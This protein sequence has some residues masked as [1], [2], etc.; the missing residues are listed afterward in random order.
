[1]DGVWGEWSDWGTCSKTC[2]PGTQTASRECQFPDPDNK[3]KE[4]EGESTKT[5]ECEVLGWSPFQG[6]CY[7]FVMQSKVWSEARTD[8]LSQ[9][10][11][12]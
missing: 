9:Q 3:G 2:G 5:Q 4:C 8:C 1:M 10:V 12:F 6:K 11:N 7:K